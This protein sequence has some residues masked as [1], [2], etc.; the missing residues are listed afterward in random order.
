MDIDKAINEVV[1]RFQDILKKDPIF[2][3]KLYESHV[4]NVRKYSIINKSDKPKTVYIYTEEGL[5]E[6]SPFS[7]F[8][9]A[10]KV[11]GLNPSSNTCNRYI[12]AFLWSPNR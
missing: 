3:V 8:S 9:L 5:I 1:E 7:S 2:D 10:H 6:G 4:D 11:L 12:G